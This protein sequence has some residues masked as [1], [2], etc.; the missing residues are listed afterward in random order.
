[1]FGLKMTPYSK[2]M[3]EVLDVELEGEYEVTVVTM[4]SSG[5]CVCGPGGF[6]ARMNYECVS[7]I[8]LICYL[9]CFVGG[10]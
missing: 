8:S 2:W 3:K 5:E 7:P 1:M 9:L 10:I 4:G 6:E